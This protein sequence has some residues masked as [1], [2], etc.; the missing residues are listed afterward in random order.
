MFKTKKHAFQDHYRLTDWELAAMSHAIV[1]YTRK[2]IS[3]ILGVPLARVNHLM[4]RSYA[5]TNTR[6]IQ[7]LKKC[8]AIFKRQVRRLA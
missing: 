6:G 7:N 8:Y 4:V 3:K 5:K 1:G 2:Q